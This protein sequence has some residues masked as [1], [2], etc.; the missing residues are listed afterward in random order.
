MQCNEGD[1]PRKFILYLKLG[2]VDLI[3]DERHYPFLHHL[4]ILS[5]GRAGT[6]H[7]KVFT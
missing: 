4:H 6:P 7:Y 2:P 5:T 3:L 1:L